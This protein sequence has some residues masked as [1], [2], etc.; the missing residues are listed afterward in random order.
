MDVWQ[1]QVTMQKET[2]TVSWETPRLAPRVLLNPRFGSAAGN[3]HSVPSLTC[4]VSWTNGLKSPYKRGAGQEHGRSGVCSVE[5]TE[6][7]FKIVDAL[8]A[9]VGG[10]KR[11]PRR[12]GGLGQRHRYR[13]EAGDEAGNRSTQ[14]VGYARPQRLSLS[15]TSS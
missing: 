6:A 11:P 2:S 7:D 3:G 9:V 13:V 15:S 14:V 4:T 8:I 12:L 5:P 10:L 1:R